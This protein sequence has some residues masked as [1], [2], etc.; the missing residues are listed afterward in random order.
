MTD[1]FRFLLFRK[2]NQSQ[3][4]FVELPMELRL[5]FTTQKQRDM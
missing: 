3:L 5:I 4:M 2:N 1:I